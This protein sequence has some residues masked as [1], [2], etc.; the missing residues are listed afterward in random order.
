MIDDYDER[1]ALA[2]QTA[3]DFGMR[4]AAHI[5][6]GIDAGKK[7]DAPLEG[8]SAGPGSHDGCLLD[9]RQI[10]PPYAGYRR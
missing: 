9:I 4:N 3:R 7:A 10:L 1:S 6:G 5:M 2:V 8:R